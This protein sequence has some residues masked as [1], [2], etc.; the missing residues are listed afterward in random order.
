MLYG[1]KTSS[2]H[3]KCV[4]IMEKVKIIILCFAEVCNYI[5]SPGFFCLVFSFVCVRDVRR[6]PS[7]GLSNTCLF[8]VISDV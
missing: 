5:K 3:L 4:I 1:I 6:S 8:Y 2:T 7:N